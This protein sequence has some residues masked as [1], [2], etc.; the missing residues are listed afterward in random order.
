MSTENQTMIAFSKK[1]QQLRIRVGFTT[2]KELAI[3]MEI[4]QTTASR[5]ENGTSRP[6][7]IDMARLLK[8]LSVHK[9]NLDDTN[10][11]CKISR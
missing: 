4:G 9:K 10:N 3:A 5:W 11:R 8:I 2:Q 1:L 6:K 7:A